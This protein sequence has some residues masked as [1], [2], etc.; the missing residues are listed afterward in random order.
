MFRFKAP[1][2]TLL[3]LLIT[4]SIVAILASISVPSY[5]GFV[6]KSRR[7]DAMSALLQVQLAQ[8]RWR[9]ANAEYAGALGA[10]HWPDGRSPEGYYRVRIER[11][12]AAEFLATAT[13]R[14]AQQSDDCGVFAINSQGPVE[15]P[16]YANA[17]C[18]NR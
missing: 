15:D 7:S 3:E 1:G 17:R 12:D 13:P 6:A 10:L 11:S 16:P 2:F 4:L 9:A 5:S 18:W 8:Q 14:G